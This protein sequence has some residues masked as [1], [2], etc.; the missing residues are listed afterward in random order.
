M[1]KRRFL[2]FAAILLLIVTC[3]ACSSDLIQREITAEEL[4]LTFDLSAKIQVGEREYQCQVSHDVTQSTVISFTGHNAFHG[5]RYQRSGG[6]DRLEY[7]ALSAEILKSGLPE[8]NWFRT[9]ADILDY[10]QSYVNLESDGNNVFK[11][12]INGIAFQ[13]TANS[14]GDIESIIA[15]DLF[16]ILFLF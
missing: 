11:G 12:S 6:I 3:S 9:I 2:L 1:I 7:Q 8:N 4:N 10:A 16:T 14:S 15:E 13:I 5:L